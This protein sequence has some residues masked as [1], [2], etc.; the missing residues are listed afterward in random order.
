[1]YLVFW[2]GFLAGMAGLGTLLLIFFFCFKYICISKEPDL[3]DL[4]RRG[5]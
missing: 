2:L 4:R 3:A 1:M 5:L